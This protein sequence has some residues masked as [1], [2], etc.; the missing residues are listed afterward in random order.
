VLIDGTLIVQREGSGADSHILG[1]N[2][3]TGA[4]E[5]T[6]PRPLSQGSH[7]TPMLWSHDGQKE[8]IVHGRG[9]VAAYDLETH[10][11]TWWVNG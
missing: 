9:S 8:L 1:L 7:S 10:E 2:P 5:W 3:A 4:T 11:N 6:I